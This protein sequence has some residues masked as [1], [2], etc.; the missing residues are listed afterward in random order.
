MKLIRFGNEKNEKPGILDEKGERLDLSGYFED[1]DEKFFASGGLEK[2]KEL[3]TKGGNSR[4]LPNL[5]GGPH[6]LQGHQ[7]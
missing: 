7:K 2:L 6:V 1:W 5:S 4:R 3:M